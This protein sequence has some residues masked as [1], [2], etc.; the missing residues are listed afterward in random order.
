MENKQ[1]RYPRTN[2]AYLK[3]N[4]DN[5]KRV[6]AMLAECEKMEDELRDLSCLVETISH[7]VN[8]W[9]GV[10]DHVCECRFPIG[11]CLKCDMRKIR[12]GIERLK[13]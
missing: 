2:N 11:G 7:T 5:E 1:T 12:E 9:E 10:S 13:Q 3:A 8:Y 4:R 6:D